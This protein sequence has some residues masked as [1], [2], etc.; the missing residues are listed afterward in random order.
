MRLV[1]R[2]LVTLLL[3]VI[4]AAGAPPDWLVEPGIGLLAGYA[5]FSSPYEDVRLK[6]R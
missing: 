1:R 4:P 6:S 5:F 3:L 2:L